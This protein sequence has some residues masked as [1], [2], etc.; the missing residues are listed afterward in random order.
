METIEY[1][2]GTGE[3]EPT[4]WHSPADLDLDS[5]GHL[6]AVALDFDGD[7][8]IDDA[9]WDSDGDG[10]ADR[11]VLDLDDDGT[12][13]AVFADGGRGLWEKPMPADL[14]P[15]EPGPATG[16][17]DVDHDGDGRPDEVLEDLDGDGFADRASPR[18]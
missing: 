5:D 1:F 4:S 7:G 18:R 16:R 17:L 9:M 15:A 3:G 14:S 6:D 12:P 11:S 10:V 2:F 8:L 13:E